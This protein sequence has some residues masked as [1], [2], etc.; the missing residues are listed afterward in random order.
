MG[1]LT[2]DLLVVFVS[3]HHA[4][5]YDRVPE[6]V[7]NEFPEGAL[8]GCSGGGVIGG[9]REVENRPGLAMTVAH[10]PDVEVVPFHVETAD[11]PDADAAPNRWEDLVHVAGDED[12]Q[13]ILLLDPFTFD[14]EQF[15][16]GL[17]FAYYPGAKI[18][19]MASGGQRRGENALFL[20]Y[21]AYRSGA[22]GV[23]LSGNVTVDTIVAQGCRPIGVPLQV[24]SANR[25]V[26]LGLDHEKPTDVLQRIYSGL[27]EH[28]QT[29]AQ[30]ALFLGVAMDPLNDT[31][32]LGDFLVRNIIGG[33]QNT[34]ALSVAEVLKEGQTVQF[35]IRD[36]K[37]SEEDL[38]NLLTQYSAR[39][40]IYEETGALLFSCLGRGEHLY[41][42][43]DHDSEMFRSKIS[44]MP[45]TGFFC[46]GEIGPIGGSTFIHSYTSAFGVFRPKN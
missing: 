22:V 26:L 14:A 30:Q 7:R 12:P 27:N 15:A 43:P 3:P 16:M 18:G 35:H 32:Q 1:H 34:G 13:F 21:N 40:P 25:N 17:D 36:A 2:A 45:M 41:G 33:N 19:G 37:T 46:N 6:L 8:I 42:R 28:E 4:T 10:L 44:S 11:L 5:E 38:D 23:A 20:T 29:L 39:K 9:G 31:P 24:T